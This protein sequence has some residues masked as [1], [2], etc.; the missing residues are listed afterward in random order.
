MIE[1]TYIELMHKEIDGIIDQEEKDKLSSYLR[2][3]NEAAQYYRDLVQ[4]TDLLKEVPE[5]NPPENLKYRILGSLNWQLYSPSQKTSSQNSFSWNWFFRPGY[6]LAYSF[7]LGVVVG[8]LVFALA[9][10]LMKSSVTLDTNDLYGT[11]GLETKKGVKDLQHIPIQ[12]NEIGGNIYLKKFNKFIIFEIEL[13]SQMQN[14]LWL[15]YE[16]SDYQFRGMQQTE[17]NGILFEEGNT[18]IEISNTKDAKYQI[19]FSK[20]SPKPASINL[21]ILA[22]DQVLLHQIIFVDP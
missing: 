2:D 21:K 13:E 17:S 15:G 19:Y 12:L 22:S 11:I 5:I 18:F 7:A 3:N 20:N 14:K 6:K 10:P 16:P 9:M 1:N 8:V 4:T